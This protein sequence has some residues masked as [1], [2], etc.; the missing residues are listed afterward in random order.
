[1]YEPLHSMK[2]SNLNYQQWKIKEYHVYGIEKFSNRIIE[3]NLHKLRRNISTV[4][5]STQST[6]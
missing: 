5:K 2:Q 4:T 6:K 1:M 3:E